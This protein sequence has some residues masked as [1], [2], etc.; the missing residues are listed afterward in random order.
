MLHRLL[1]LCLCA[2]VV[3]CASM[4]ETQPPSTANEEL[5]LS[6]AVDEAV[7]QIAPNVA[8][9][10]RVFVDDSDF[11]S[12][13][14][15]R[16]AVSAINDALLADGYRLVP[17]RA[18]AETVVEIRAGALSINKQ[19]RLWLGIPSFS[20]P[21]PLAGRLDT[22]ELDLFKSTKRTG[23]AKFGLTFYDA[24]SGN[25]LDSV[26]PVYGYSHLDEKKILMIGWSD[27][28]LLPPG[29]DTRAPPPSD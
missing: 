5:L 10:N 26:G 28:D 2:T 9:D 23:I 6:H 3:G 27:S 14:D 22:P 20:L 7:T 21:I 8:P 12:E 19:E 13:S 29:T 16:Y 1:I 25:M 4:R 18:A 17:T 24:D 15:T 11:K